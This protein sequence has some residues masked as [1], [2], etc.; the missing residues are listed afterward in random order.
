MC[1]TSTYEA[2]LKS[3]TAEI[4]A[5]AKA[6][7]DGGSYIN[8]VCSGGVDFTADVSVSAS[9]TQVLLDIPYKVLSQNSRLLS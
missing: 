8:D 4:A 5:K 7:Y 2:F 3:K 1:V 6:W 9:L